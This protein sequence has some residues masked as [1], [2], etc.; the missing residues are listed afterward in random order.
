MPFPHFREQDDRDSLAFL[1]VCSMRRL[2]NRIH[3]TVY[4]N[5]TGRRSTDPASSPMSPVGPGVNVMEKVCA[6]L[7]H[8]LDTW[9]NSLP[10]AIRPD[11]QTHIPQDI[12]DGWLR[13]RYW[14]ARHIIFRP[15][16]V[17][18]T[19]LPENE[20]IAP[21]SILEDCQVCLESCQNFLA[22]AGFLLKERTQYTWMIIQSYVE[23]CSRCIV[24]YLMFNVVDLWRARWF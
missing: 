6:E 17:H 4:A 5:P 7:A 9:Y 2:L 8:Q 1:A 22:T 20:E 24:L 12:L 16:V 11:L 13:L 15:C 21:L 23:T 14:S 10:D 18:V 19:M 3:S